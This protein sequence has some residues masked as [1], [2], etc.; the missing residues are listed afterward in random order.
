MRQM[1]NTHEYVARSRAVVYEHPRP[2]TRPIAV[3]PRGS[4]VQGSA[5]SSS[6]WIKTA[7]GDFMLDDGSLQLISVAR[8]PAP[9]PFDKAFELPLDANLDAATS[10]MT[11]DGSLHISVPKIR[12]GRPASSR[13]CMPQA[14]QDFN[15]QPPAN[16]RS[17]ER[18][19]TPKQASEKS[20]QPH[21]VQVRT[22]ERA[23]DAQ[24]PK[25][26]P[27]SANVSEPRSS[28]S[29]Q[30]AASRPTSAPAPKKASPRDNL[31]TKH[32]QKAEPILQESTVRAENVQRPIESMEEW[33]ADESGGFVRIR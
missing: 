20:R 29:S 5:P 1:T 31:P 33:V 30:T 3:L 6:G 25:P 8:P 14:A 22:V 18:V 9:V 4:I 13:M 24:P 28:T 2:G 26:R 32:L 16:A 19:S 21:N 7:D 17:A 11:K 23:H 10:E 15:L 27:E 12:R